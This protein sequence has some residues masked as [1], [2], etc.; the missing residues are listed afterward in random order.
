MQRFRVVYQRISRESLKLTRYTH[1]ALGE[2]E[3]QENTSDKWDI[4]CIV[5]TKERCI[6]YGM[7]QRKTL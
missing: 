7:V 6:A 3:D 4:P 2:C 5:Y 1:E